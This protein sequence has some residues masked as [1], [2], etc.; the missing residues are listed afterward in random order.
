MSGLL[1]GAC[2]MLTL[3]DDKATVVAKIDTK[4]DA[5]DDDG[6]GGGDADGGGDDVDGGGDGYGEHGD[7]VQVAMRRRIW[8]VAGLPEGP[9]RAAQYTAQHTALRI[10]DKTRQDKTRPRS[11]HTT[12]P[13]KTRPE[14]TQINLAQA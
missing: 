14:K 11:R 9:V 2:G 7:S 10:Q 13:D 6:H 5:D 12:R 3:H 1:V 8:W 4:K